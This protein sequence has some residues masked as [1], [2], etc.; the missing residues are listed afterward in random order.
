[1]A[2][3]STPPT[4]TG[5]AVL[6]SPVSWRGP[7][8][9]IKPVFAN[10]WPQCGLTNLTPRLELRLPHEP[11]RIQP[12]CGKHGPARLQ[13]G[14]PATQCPGLSWRSVHLRGSIWRRH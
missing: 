9:M 10:L 2:A 8:D 11:D 4:G 13:F 5:R 3:A 6:G 7:A 1:G 14:S 12:A